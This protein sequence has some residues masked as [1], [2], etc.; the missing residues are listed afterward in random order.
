V[1]ILKENTKSSIMAVCD[2]VNSV[3]AIN[4]INWEMLVAVLIVYPR[5]MVVE[6]KYVMY[7]NSYYLHSQILNQILLEK[8]IS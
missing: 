8:D 6:I 7:I 1:Q 2:H 5:T 4:D 3:F